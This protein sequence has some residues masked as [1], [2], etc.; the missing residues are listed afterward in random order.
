[1]ISDEDVTRLAER[2]VEAFSV[3][4]YVLRQREMDA[5]FELDHLIHNQPQDALVV[6]E[7]IAVRELIN[8]TFEGIAVGPLRD[9]LMIYGDRYDSH[10]MAIRQRNKAFD[11]MHSMAVEGM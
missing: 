9:F 8:W 10:L 5:W 2:W 4:P 11:E 6:F 7:R 1:M 3:E